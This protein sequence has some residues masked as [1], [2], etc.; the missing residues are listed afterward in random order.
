M[1][2]NESNEKIM[3]LTKSKIKDH[4]NNILQRLQLDRNIQ[5]ITIKN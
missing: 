3:S 1:L 4:K 2:D 5:K